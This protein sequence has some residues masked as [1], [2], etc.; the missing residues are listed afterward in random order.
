MG[1]DKK[2]Q[3]RYITIADNCINLSCTISHQP[4]CNTFT[5]ARTFSA[6]AAA[7][8]WSV[9]VGP[10]ASTACMRPL[11]QPPWHWKYEMK[12]HRGMINESRVSCH[13]QNANGKTSYSIF[14]SWGGCLPGQLLATAI[15]K[16]RSQYS[17]PW[18]MIAVRCAHCVTKQSLT[19]RQQG[20]PWMVEKWHKTCTNA[21][22]SSMRHEIIQ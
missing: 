6:P 7:Q 19:N 10:K 9:D 14:N 22:C 15:Y 16:I 8:P 3:T 12:K 2:Y 11:R 18:H 17:E 5:Q 20:E 1:G 13:A 21:S 4:C